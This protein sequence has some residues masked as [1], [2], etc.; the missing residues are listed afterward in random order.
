MFIH[1]V[2][3]KKWPES[4]S[5]PS[6]LLCGPM[7]YMP[8]QRGSYLRYWCW[9]HYRIL[10]KWSLTYT[11]FDEGVRG[12]PVA[13]KPSI[14]TLNR[15]IS[16]SSGSGRFGQMH[17]SS[18]SLPSL[19]IALIESQCNHDY[20][21]LILVEASRILL[22]PLS[23]H[24]LL[25]FIIII[26]IQSFLFFLSNQQWERKHWNGCCWWWWWWM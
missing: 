1:E 19:E 7:K 11:I 5:K 17:S 24:W 22:G 8:D 10:I 16:I 9:V 15:W 2:T 18:S 23:G 25:L 13:K 26:I 21:I 4:E 3:S 12:E 6:I 20:K 14:F